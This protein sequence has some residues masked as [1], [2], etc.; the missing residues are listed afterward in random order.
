[1][2]SPFYFI[3]KPVGGERYKNTVDVGGVDFIV[4]TSDEDHKFSNR[5]AIVESLPSSYSGPIRVGDT[6]LV[7]HNV[8]KFYND[9]KGRIKSSGSFFRDDLF[10]VDSEQ[11]FLFKSDGKWMAH[12]RYCFVSPIKDDNFS[13]K[14]SAKFT[15]LI[16]VMRYPNDMLVSKGV[17]PGDKVSFRPDS[18]YEFF[19]DGELM[20]RVYDH[21][22]TM[23]L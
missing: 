11:F 1:M 12:D 16:G 3:V 18:E 22:I 6:L 23:I 15:P 19:V 4:N 8:F 21:H 14:S 2:K 9:I 10:F 7:H 20:Y 17:M 13:L 5:E